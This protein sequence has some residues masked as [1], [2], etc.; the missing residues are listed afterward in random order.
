[1]SQTSTIPRYR[2]D[3][4]L[5][6]ASNA[7]FRF[8]N[9]E[10][11]Q[12]S[13]R[14]NL[15]ERL[16]DIGGRVSSAWVFMSVAGLCAAIGFGLYAAFNAQI[17]IAGLIDPMNNNIVPQYILWIIGIAIS[18]V[19]M[20]LG[21]LI[22]EGLSEGFETDP[23][24]GTK[25]H[26]SKI[27]LAVVGFAGAV[28]YIGYQFYLVKSAGEASGI[29]KST[30][31]SY[32]PYVVV[33]IATLELLIG[34]LIVHMTF[35]YLMY[36]ISRIWISNTVRKMN[37]AARETN[38]NYRQYLL[39][40]E[41]YNRENPNQQIET[42]GSTNIRKAIAYYSGINLTDVNIESE[43][44]QVLGTSQNDQTQSRQQNNLNNTY[45]A[46]DNNIPSQNQNGNNSNDDI[47]Q[48][49][50]DFMNDTTDENLTA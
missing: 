41:A 48:T 35:G 7:A 45:P 12:R 11:K 49:F 24:T 8:T 23:Y 5:N 21:H 42:E 10:S 13:Q 4:M 47:R 34:A 19:G 2:V 29:D 20:T 33:G 46:S 50:D 44:P 15:S 31:L 27:W 6:K 25:S 43:P 16:E 28:I 1:M 39:Y 30:G 14:Q 37:T 17:A 3:N 26:S 18:I 36:F 38:E 32:L 40:F 9:F 22:Y